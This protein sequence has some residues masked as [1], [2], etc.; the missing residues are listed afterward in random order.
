M[1]RPWV[2]IQRNSTSGTGARSR[3][4][5]ELWSELKR[6]GLV[7]R[8]FAN[9]ETM[10]TRLADPAAREHLACVVAAGGDGTVA[11]VVNRY[12]GVTLAMLPLGTENLLAKYLGIRP[13]GVHVAELIA[14]GSRRWLDVGQL[15]GRRFTLMASCGFDAA[16][17][18]GTHAN[19]RGNIRKWHYVPPIWNS[20]RKYDHPPLRIFV[21]DETQ[22]RTARLLMAVNLP[23]Y[24]LGIPFAPQA[25]GEDGQLDLCL[26]ERGS[27]FQMV[28]YLGHVIAGRHQTLPDVTCLRA[29]RVRIEADVTVPWQMDGDP[30]G[31][32]PVELQVLPRAVEV[33]AP[34]P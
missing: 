7:P 13:S 11:D 27:T 16:V 31:F 25:S 14:S 22:P 12:P 3:L 1:K 9:R 6:H 34:Q 2:A 26:F 28:R 23:V 33:F 21:D 19:R 5:L 10:Q 20:I 17:V 30:A 4:L 24:A 8:M 15:N 29:S 18:H 32:T